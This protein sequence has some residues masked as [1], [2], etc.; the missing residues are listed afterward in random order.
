MAPGKGAH[1]WFSGPTGA[2]A[3]PLASAQPRGGFPELHQAGFSCGA[4]WALGFEN[5]LK[6][7][8]YPNNMSKTFLFLLKR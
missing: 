5:I 7:L 2:R 3:R 8:D 1:G 6:T 4:F